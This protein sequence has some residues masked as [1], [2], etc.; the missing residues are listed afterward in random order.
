MTITWR[1]L[2]KML[3]AILQQLL[4]TP[5]EENHLPLVQNGIDLIKRL[6]GGQ[7]P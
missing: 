4:E 5:A 6:N 2:A 7:L 3:L 1:Y